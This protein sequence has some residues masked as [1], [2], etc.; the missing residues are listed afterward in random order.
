MRWITTGVTS[1]SW[2]RA[3]PPPRGRSNPDN[4]HPRDGDGV[5]PGVVTDAFERSGS[6][7]R[8][9]REHRR[10]ARLL[11]QLPPRRYSHRALS[12]HAHVVSGSVGL[13]ASRRWRPDRQVNRRVGA[14]PRIRCLYRRRFVRHLEELRSTS[15]KAAGSPSP[16]R[17]PSGIR[18]L[19]V[20]LAPKPIWAPDH[21]CYRRQRLDSARERQDHRHAAPG[22]T[23]ACSLRW[24]ASTHKDP[25]IGHGH[26][27]G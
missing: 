26:H 13:S 11:M 17:R 10:G 6:R 14:Y 19:V 20:K 25:D 16:R 4:G 2:R 18:E 9:A 12:R 21:P 23:Q 5:V 24:I 15:R 27:V 8:L 22:H 1:S 3:R 7:D